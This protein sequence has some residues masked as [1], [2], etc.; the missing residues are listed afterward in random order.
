M[1][2]DNVRRNMHGTKSSRRVN[3]KVHRN[4]HMKLNE[5]KEKYD[6]SDHNLLEIELKIT[7]ETKEYKKRNR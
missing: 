2:T 5:G 6:F 7:E 1:M 3:E 4:F